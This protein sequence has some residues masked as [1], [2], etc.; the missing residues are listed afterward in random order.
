MDQ[1]QVTRNRMRKTA[2]HEAGHVIVQHAR[3]RVVEARILPDVIAHSVAESPDPV[4]AIEWGE[5]M[6]YSLS[7]PS[8]V[9]TVAGVA[10]VVAEFLDTSSG[11]DQHH[12]M[13]LTRLFVELWQ[14]AGWDFSSE[15]AEVISDGWKERE[16]AVKEAVFL[17]RKHRRE[18]W[19]VVDLLMNNEKGNRVSSANLCQI[20]ASR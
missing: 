20:F 14:N 10:G 1:E 15:G 13:E 5:A 19:E 16:D 3:S 6:T 9:D 11:F 4:K 8:E 2:I 18:F 7:G 17:L 12:P